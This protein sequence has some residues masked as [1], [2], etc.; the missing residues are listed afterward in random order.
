MR[1]KFHPIECPT[2]VLDNSLQAGQKID[3]WNEQA[4]FF[5]YLGPSPTHAWSASLILSL[6][7][8]CTLPQFHFKYDNTFETLWNYLI[9]QTIEVWIY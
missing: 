5:I 3:K 8:G 2:Y 9:S 7:T 4:R 6:T 1:R